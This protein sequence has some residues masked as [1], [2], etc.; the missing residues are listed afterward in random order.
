M[1]SERGIGTPNESPADG[2]EAFYRAFDSPLMRQIRREAYGEDIGQHSWVRAD[3][4]RR[5][6]RRLE[7]SS[8]SRLVDLGCG[9]CGPL[10]F[11]LG[12]V[13]CSGAGVDASPS[14]LRAG[15]ARASSLGV[16]AL[17][18][19]HEAD[20]NAPLLLE[21]ASFDAAV[22]F[23]VVLHLRDRAR[24][25]REIGK[26]LR[27]G[28]R[29]LFTDAGVVTGSVSNEEV[30]R[31]SAYGYTEFVAPGF[32]ERLLE[33]AGF[34]VIEIEDRTASV[35]AN[36]SGRLSAMKTHRDELERMSGAADL[37]AQLTYLEMVV[38]LSR[39]EAVSRI[40]YLAEA[41]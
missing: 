34:R 30:A 18:S 9:P 27:P 15:R 40:M 13:R 16:E 19:V 41:P 35:L 21:A 20:L 11:L 5:D 10:T 22:S 6:V 29:L 7:L 4:L 28:G 36:A 31:R 23:D 17:L 32:N 37:D 8:S 2:Y 25:F 33:S 24:F 39:R 38:E 12:L 26:L 1:V 3:D 14:A